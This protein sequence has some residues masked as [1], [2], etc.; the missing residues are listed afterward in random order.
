MT[1]AREELIGSELIGVDAWLLLL[2]SQELVILGLLGKK[3][4][5]NVIWF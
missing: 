4:R 5:L 3:L 1:V 2:L